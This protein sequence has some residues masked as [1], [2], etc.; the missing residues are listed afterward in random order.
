MHPLETYLQDLAQIRTSGANVKEL[1]FYPAL[2]DLLD[3]AGKELKPKVQSVLSLKNQGGGMP[4]GGLFT[5]SQ[6]RKVSYESILSQIPERGAIEVKGPEENAID[7]A[8]SKQVEGYAQRYGLV[9][10]T[11][12]REFLL[13]KTIFGEKSQIFESYSLASDEPSFWK[14]THHPRTAVTEHGTR[15][16]EFLKRALMY[17]AE[18]TEP[19]DLAWF[20]ASY[21]RDAHALIDAPHDVPAL[22]SLRL[23]MHQA[24]NMEFTGE[25]GEHFFRSTL[26]QTLFYGIFSAWVLWHHEKP[27]RDDHFDWRLSAYELKVPV[28][29]SLFQQ[30]SG[31]RQMQALGLTKY[32]DLSGEALNRVNRGAFFAK[33]DKGQAVQYFYEPF[34][35]AYDPELR[36]ELGV[37]YTPHEIVEYMVERVDRVLRDELGLPDGL[38]DPNVYVLDPCC[39]TGA[40][41]LE[42]LKRIAKTI[43]KKNDDALLGYELK[44]AATQRVFGFEI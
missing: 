21:A 12:L 44:K 24:L 32:L 1:S 36:K 28:I 30:L 39:G 23:S 19:K 37:W 18:L 16:M 15:I 22:E 8:H 7:V 5:A 11:N 38:A 4:D 34:L 27:T 40:Y 17:Q 41:P 10:V 35:E 25:K 14:L 43:N 13:V 33:F 29:Q 3:A 6:L 26:I 20:L 31:P 9:L 42:V 2:K